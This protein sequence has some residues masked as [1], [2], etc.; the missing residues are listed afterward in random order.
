MNVSSVVATSRAVHLFTCKGGGE[1]EEGRAFSV[2]RVR[3][4]SRG[5]VVETCFLLYDFF[6]VV[7]VLSSSHFAQKCPKG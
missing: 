1:E 6:F 3:V 2:A 5:S 4:V 7:V